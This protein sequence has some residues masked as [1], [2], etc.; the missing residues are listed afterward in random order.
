MYNFTMKTRSDGKD[1]SSCGGM[2]AVSRNGASCKLARM[3]VAEGMEDAPVTLMSGD[4]VSMEFPSLSW[5]AG[6][7]Y[8]EGQ[9]RLR[10]VDFAAFSGL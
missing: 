1:E 2:V 4:T 3:M 10:M 9:N 5:L 6:K 7:T 8:S